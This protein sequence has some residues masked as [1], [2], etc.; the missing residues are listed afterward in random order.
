[1]ARMLP[2]QAAPAYGGIMDHVADVLSKV[3]RKR[4]LGQH[5]DAALIAHEARAWLQHELPSLRN[6]WNI[7]SFKDGVLFIECGDS[8]TA[9][10]CQGIGHRLLEHLRKQMPQSPL[11]SVRIGRSE[12]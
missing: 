10:E 9:Q 3:L 4:G 6:A 5:A 12:Q 8:I 11:S 2:L 7:R 1:M